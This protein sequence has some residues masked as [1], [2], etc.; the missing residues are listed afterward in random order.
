MR[1][2]D[3]LTLKGRIEHYIARRIQAGQLRPGE[4]LQMAVIAKDLDVS[5]TPVREVLQALTAR[6]VLTEKPN[7]GYF[8]P[9]VDQ[10]ELA[11]IYDVIAILDQACMERSLELLIEEDYHRMEELIAKMDVAIQFKDYREYSEFQFA[12]HY[13]Y[14]NKCGNDVLIRTLDDLLMSP[15]PILMEADPEKEQARIDAL[16]RANDEHRKIVAALREKDMEKL[17]VL[18]S[19]HWRE[20]VVDTRK[21]PLFL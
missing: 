4:K 5:T 17:A 10:D 14:I 3:T 16:H 2:G 18:V 8:V 9:E 6:G 15:I 13:T 11:R 21:S 12:F 7:K 1:E 20:D 19:H